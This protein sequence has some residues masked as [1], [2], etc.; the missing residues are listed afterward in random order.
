MKMIKVAL[1][2][3]AL[4]PFAVLADEEITIS[5][6]AQ[7]VRDY[8]GQIES[9]GPGVYLFN[10]G[11]FAGL[12]VSIGQDGLHY[13]MGMLKYL[14]DSA[15]DGTDTKSMAQAKIE[16]LA[17]LSRRYE[18]AE[19]IAATSGKDKAVPGV[20]SCLSRVPGRPGPVFY[21]GS[22]T[23]SAKT[24]FYIYR[25]DGSYNMYYA[26][27]QASASAMVNLP[28]GV[29]TLQPTHRTDTV[30]MDHATG[31]SDYQIAFGSVWS[32]RSSQMTSFAFTHNISAS[33]AVYGMGDCVGYVSVNDRLAYPY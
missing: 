32:Y 13:D 26:R 8:Q 22:V 30:A 3:M 33:S 9:V 19:K 25:E 7:F 17:E 24:G 4:T 23:V 29:S 15:E 6:E 27:A 18:S 10:Q 14:V 28:I 21:T 1:L 20:I 12:E 31:E 11:T 2:A 5:S 16:T